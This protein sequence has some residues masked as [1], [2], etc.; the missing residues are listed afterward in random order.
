MNPVQAARRGVSGSALLLT[1]L[2]L[3]GLTL[4]SLAGAKDVILQRKI[5]ANEA[6][7]KTAEQAADHALSW[8]ESWLLST[9]Q[10]QAGQHCETPCE[11]D[12]VFERDSDLI[13]S[14]WPPDSGPWMQHGKSP[15]RDPFSDR[16]QSGH[17]LYQYGLWRISEAHRDPIVSPD[18]ERVVFYR[19]VTRGLDPTSRHTAVLESILALPEQPSAAITDQTRAQNIG[20]FCAQRSTP[21][22]GR[23]AWRRVNH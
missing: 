20:M 3:T 22:C 11:S 5:E 7:Q 10:L 8:A 6:A 19:L 17:P 2:L 1:L 18:M 9:S 15:G 13:S 16:V 23:V 14:T 12:G 21:F 4:L